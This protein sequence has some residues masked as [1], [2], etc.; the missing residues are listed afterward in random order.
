VSTDPAEYPSRA[1]ILTIRAV[2]VD[3]PAVSAQGDATVMNSESGRIRMPRGRRERRPGRVAP[4]A[5]GLLTTAARLLPAA[6]R[7]RYAEEYRSELGDLAQSGL[8]RIRQ[9][10]YAL[11][12]LLRVLPLGLVL[13]SL[14]RRSAAP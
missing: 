8:G 11:C 14:R 4:S 6:D 7:A 13:R 10:R 1:A 3:E 5:A 12:Q 2:P 9:L